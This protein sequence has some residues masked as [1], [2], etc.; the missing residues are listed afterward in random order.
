MKY[1]TVINEF[2]RVYVAEKPLKVYERSVI[3]RGD[4]LFFLIR[5]D[6]EKK[7][8]IICPFKYVLP[9]RFIPEKEGIFKFRDKN[10]RYIVCKCDGENALALRRMFT[11]TRPRLVGLTPTIGLGD[12]IGIATP[13]HIRAIRGFGFP[14]VLA[15]Q[16]IREIQRTGRTLQEVLDDVSWAV[17]QEGYRMGF[18]ADADHLKRKEDVED[19]FQAGF[20]MYTVDPSDY[21]NSEADNY[22]V[23]VLKERFNGLPWSEMG[24]GKERFLKVYL[25]KRLTLYLPDGEI[26]E[27]KFS[28]ES[29]MRAAVKFSNAILFVVRVYRR[30]KSLF[31]RRRFDFEVSIDETESPTSALEHF[32]IVSE[33][34]RLGVRFHGLAPRFV[35]RFEKAIDYIGDLKEFEENFLTHILISRALGPY[36]ISIHSGSDKFSIYP[37]V[38]RLSPDMVHLKTSGT[39]YLESLRVVARHEPNLFRE[40]I[41]YSLK[42]F[43][44]DRR[45]YFTSAD[46][47][48]MPNSD[49]ILDRELERAFLESSSG[50][51]ILHITFGSILTARSEDGK[52]L[53]RERIKRVLFDNE[54]EFYETIAAHIR[55]HIESLF[56]QK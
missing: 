14:P 41:K 33:L 35:G 51:Q 31:G 48:F 16:S 3:R 23:S 38:G 49:D 36:K 20:T 30:L 2:M 40:I 21:V 1:S 56:G 34:R 5:E 26:R 45:S 19:A 52:W 6:I 28:E 29:L 55:R 10:L 47:K 4:C 15:Q 43:E 7:L 54:E 46:P 44:S 24:I 12:R 27:L 9:E 22:P 18:A 8:V 39:S 32:F 53:F 25:K 50:R 17:F 13:G 42:C 11:F 37:I